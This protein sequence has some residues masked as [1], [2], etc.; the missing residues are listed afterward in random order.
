MGLLDK[1]AK[2]S[3]GL[4]KDAQVGATKS[5]TLP[6]VPDKIRLFRSLNRE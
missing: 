5:S 4:L 3:A 1:P 6:T 2:I